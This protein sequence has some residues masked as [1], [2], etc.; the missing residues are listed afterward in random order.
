[1]IRTIPHSK[2]LPGTVRIT[3]SGLE[4]R[5]KTKTP[6]KK[7]SEIFPEAMLVIKLFK[8]NKGFPY[9]IDKKIRASLR[10]S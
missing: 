5:E 3:A 8:K 7:S 1:M 2:I 6:W 10:G 4:A 9:L